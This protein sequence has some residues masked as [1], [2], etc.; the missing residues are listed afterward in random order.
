[1]GLSQ[2]QAVYR[3]GGKTLLHLLVDKLYHFEFSE[4]FMLL[5][6]YTAPKQGF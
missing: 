1:M 4:E 5:Q 2:R 3:A 6:T